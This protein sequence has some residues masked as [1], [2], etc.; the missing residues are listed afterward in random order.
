MQSLMKE[1]MEL[2]DPYELGWHLV[3]DMVKIAEV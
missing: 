2:Q 1:K 3:F